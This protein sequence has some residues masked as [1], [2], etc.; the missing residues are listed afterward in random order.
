MHIGVILND[1]KVASRVMRRLADHDK[2]AFDRVCE[3][4]EGAKFTRRR[5]GTATYTWATVQG[6]EID[7]PWPANRWPRGV[8]A[9]TVA[10]EF[11]LVS[12]STLCSLANGTSLDN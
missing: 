9:C 7:G 5:Y 8:L 10:L 2:D 1:R 4:Y 12:E 6:R 3:L 11:G